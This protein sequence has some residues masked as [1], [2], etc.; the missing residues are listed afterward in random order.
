M[1]EVVGDIPNV[2]YYFDDVLVATAT[3]DEHMV[4]LRHVFQRVREAR[5]T[6]K[7]KKSE[8]GS[9]TTSFLGHIVG[10]GLLQPQKD[11]SDKIVSA[12]RP[13]SKKELRAFL[14]LTGYYREFVPNYA[15]I[16]HPLTELTKKGSPNKLEW[17]DEHQ[18]AFQKLKAMM[19]RR[20][21]LKAP[22]L[23]R[24]FVLRTDA[25]S[26]SLGAVLLQEH[27]GLLHPV[28]YASRKLL[29][30]EVAYSTI[31]RECLAI[32]WGVQKFHVYLYGRPF[33]LQSDHQPLKYINS[34]RQINTRVLRWSLL[35]MDY[36][37]HVEYIQGSDNVGADYL[38]RTSLTT[39]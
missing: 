12:K 15:E 26:R 35:L 22:N 11:T 20:P 8:I 14:G 18:D 1:R 33:V 39:Y 19:S 21:I 13:E 6:I 3:W 17:R 31:E 10:Q 28:S 37:F 27:N 34:A 4:T 25:S 36:D 30:R 32:V 9:P 5:L 7:P 16:S 29:P 24:P 38:S 2:Y 23:E